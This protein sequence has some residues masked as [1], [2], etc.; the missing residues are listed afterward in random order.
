MHPKT[1]CSAIGT[2]GVERGV[3][4]VHQINLHD[5]L[6]SVL[7]NFWCTIVT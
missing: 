2:D 6:H 7:Y 5:V 3:H 4:H 1:V